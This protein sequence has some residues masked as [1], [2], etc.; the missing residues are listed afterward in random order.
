MQQVPFRFRGMDFRC[1]VFIVVSLLP[2]ILGQERDFSLTEGHI[3]HQSLS[4][5]VCLVCLAI[6][7][8]PALFSDLMDPHGKPVLVSLSL[9]R[10]FNACAVEIICCIFIYLYVMSHDIYIYVCMYSINFY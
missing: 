9:A 1:V 6:L 4:L 7:S 10:F 2:A 3:L 8:F 5:Q